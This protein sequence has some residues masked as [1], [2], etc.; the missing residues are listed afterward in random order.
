M[1]VG[2]SIVKP[3]SSPVKATWVTLVKLS[4]VID[5]CVPIGPLVGVTELMIGP[6]DAHVTVNG[7]EL[8]AVPLAVCTEMGPVVASF[9]TSAVMLVGE[10]TVNDPAAPLNAT[11]LTPMKPVP[12]ID[13][14]VPGGPLVGVKEV[15]VS[16]LVST[17]HVRSAGVCSM[18]PAVSVARTRKV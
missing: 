18:F 15:I 9:G 3:P 13:T 16:G 5:T 2:E 14:L 6:G 1:L 8:V 11:R 12:V 17:V 10:L 7:D 4:P